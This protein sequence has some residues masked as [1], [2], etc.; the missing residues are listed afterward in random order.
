MATKRKA[1]TNS[2]GKRGCFISIRV[3]PYGNVRR[4][5]TRISKLVKAKV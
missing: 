2:C 4:R 5:R 3:L 1:M